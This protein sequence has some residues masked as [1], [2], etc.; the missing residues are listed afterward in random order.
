MNHACTADE[1]PQ[2]AHSTHAD[3][4]NHRHLAHDAPTPALQG[5]ALNRVA[6][7]ATLHCLSGC[8]IG[9]ALGVVIGTALGRSYLETIALAVALAFVS[10]YLMTMLPLARAGLAWRQAAKLAL[11]A[12]PVNRWLIA[13]GQ[14]HALAHS[15]HAHH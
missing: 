11:A 1:P 5:A 13:R 7:S 15:H 2:H 8:A 10:G 9:E 3:H 14:G 6:A 4:A 12:Y